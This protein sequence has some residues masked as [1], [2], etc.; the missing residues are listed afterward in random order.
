MRDAVALFCFMGGPT[1]EEVSSLYVALEFRPESS[2]PKQ[3]K[4]LDC[5][6]M[7]DNITNL[8]NLK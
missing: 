4:G 5:M 1:S 3:F 7:Y 6:I 8:Q 2:T